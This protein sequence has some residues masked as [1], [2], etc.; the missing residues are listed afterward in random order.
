MENNNLE[1][2]DFEKYDKE[3]EE[4]YIF[5]SAE[6]AETILVQNNE[7]VQ[8]QD[9]NQIREQKEKEYSELMDKLEKQ[10][11]E[12]CIQLLPTIFMNINKITTPIVNVS[13]KMEQTQNK[14]TETESENIMQTLLNFMKD[15]NSEFKEKMGR[16]M[17]YSEM[18]NLY[19]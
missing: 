10:G 1:N 13:C 2:N 12:K 8:E 17:T 14:E 19:G 9:E 16:N 18:R 5:P 3:I 11:E 7:Q 15:G 4:L 6:E